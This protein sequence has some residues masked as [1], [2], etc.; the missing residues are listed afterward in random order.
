[1]KETGPQKQGDS[2]LIKLT[3]L[4]R[5]VTMQYSARLFRQRVSSP[6]YEALDQLSSV[7]QLAN[8]SMSVCC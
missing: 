2:V 7:D 5:Q 1:M 8:A 3:T 4:C 6:T